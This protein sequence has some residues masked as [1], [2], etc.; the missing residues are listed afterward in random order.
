MCSAGNKKSSAADKAATTM[1]LGALNPQCLNA[2]LTYCE[3]RAVSGQ[4]YVDLNGKAVRGD[5]MK[6]MLKSPSTK[7]HSLN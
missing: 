3:E 1:N 2:T 4:A 5:S 7:C 6:S